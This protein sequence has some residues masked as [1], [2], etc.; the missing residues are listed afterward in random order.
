M[1]KLIAA[2]VLI[3]SAVA[4]RA[5]A[6]DRRQMFTDPDMNACWFG[7]AT[8]CDA[9]ARADG[10]S[11]MGLFCRQIGKAD[12]CMPA[13]QAFDIALAAGPST[14]IN[15]GGS[16]DEIKDKRFWLVLLIGRAADRA[17]AAKSDAAIEG[18]RAVIAIVPEN[19]RWD[20]FRQMLKDKGL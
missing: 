18:L 6:E 1:R 9:W 11:T 7:E 12:R 4:G 19:I 13:E 8:G 2:V 20:G 5:C 17:R 10:Y 14:T 3:S 16:E 15:G